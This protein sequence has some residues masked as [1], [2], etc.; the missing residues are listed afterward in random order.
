MVLRIGVDPKDQSRIGIFTR[1]GEFS[2]VVDVIKK[3]IDDTK[4]DVQDA[5]ADVKKVQDVVDN[6]TGIIL[7]DVYKQIDGAIQSWDGEVEPTLNNYP[8]NEWTTNE[9]RSKHVGGHV[10]VLHHRQ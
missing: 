9:E 2:D 1:H 8:A 6:I 10:P 4:K 7:P 5:A 3:D